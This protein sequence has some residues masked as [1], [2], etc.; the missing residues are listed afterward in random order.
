[1]S[2]NLCNMTKISG[3]YEMKLKYIDNKGRGC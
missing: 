3:K 1:M 2:L